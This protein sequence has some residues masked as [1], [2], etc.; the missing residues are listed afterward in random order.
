M[1][2][3]ADEGLAQAKEEILREAEALANSL[4]EDP[5]KSESE[6]RDEVRAF[7]EASVSQVQADLDAWSTTRMET[8]LPEISQKVFL[9]LGNKNIQAIELGIVTSSIAAQHFVSYSLPASLTAQINVLSIP[10]IT[11]LTGL[12]TQDNGTS[13]SAMSLGDKSAFTS[14]GPA[15]GQPVSP[16]GLLTFAQAR[17]KVSATLGGGSS[18]VLG[19]AEKNFYKPVV[20]PLI[21]SFATDPAAFTLNL[22][23]NAFSAYA[24]GAMGAGFLSFDPMTGNLGVGFPVDLV[25]VGVGGLNLNS[26][27]LGSFFPA[28]SPLAL[29]KLQFQAAVNNPGN[30]AGLPRNV[31]MMLKGVSMGYSAGSGFNFSFGSSWDGLTLGAGSQGWSIQSN[32]NGLQMPKV[33]GSLAGQIGINNS[34]TSCLS[35]DWNGPAR[36]NPG[37]IVTG[38]AQAQ[39]SEL[40]QN[41]RE[42]SNRFGLTRLGNIFSGVSAYA[43][44]AADFFRN[45]GPGFDMGLAGMKFGITRPG[46][47]MPNLGRGDLMPKIHLPGDTPSTPSNPMDGQQ[48]RMEPAPGTAPPGGGMS[49]APAAS[50]NQSKAAG[51]SGSFIETE[52]VV[53]VPKTVTG[54]SVYPINTG[55]GNMLYMA[56]DFLVPGRSLFIQ[57][58]RAYNSFNSHR[59]G[60][61]GFGWSFSYGMGLEPEADSSVVLVLGDGSRR[62]Y[63]SD[64]ASGY[65]PPPGTFSKL[66][67]EAD[68]SFKLTHKHGTAYSFSPEGRLL[69]IEDKNA[70]AIT[71]SYESGRLVAVA[72]PSGRALTFTHDASSRIAKISD[73]AGAETLY[74]YDASG[75][76][77]RV[78]GPGGY[79]GLY[80]YDSRHRL[81]AYDDGRSQLP[82][83]K[84]SFVY[85]EFGRVKEER[86]AAGGLLERFDYRITAQGLVT[87]VT[88]AQGAETVDR[89][90][91]LG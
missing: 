69:R 91:N 22:A 19:W 27:G 26:M 18:G 20:A 32:M 2:A 80:S 35:G 12:P 17:R 51:G 38:W 29:N 37:G 21:R 74:E 25:Q 24:M 4:Y 56:E 11:A 58:L 61:L 82:L 10:Q 6:I 77:A 7:I 52:N 14:L 33:V 87:T 9:E 84:G 46:A 23:F 83:D 64:G 30:A 75:N 41:E 59:D 72:D 47:G 3:E 71:L 70:N 28:G 34:G 48:C 88:N 53:N 5:F 49:L 43:R 36:F 40:W 50:P 67:K 42:D 54:Q 73:P 63:Q 86:D 31:D 85:D 39:L 89:Y 45:L 8:L 62:R 68:G 81:T 16:Q 57:M 65:T 66:A 76:L 60:P 90:D 13:A 1:Q 78:A 79:E 44:G 55:T 15:W